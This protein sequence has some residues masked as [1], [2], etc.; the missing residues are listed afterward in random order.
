MKFNVTKIK[1]IAET[2][3]K[4][5]KNRMYIFPVGESRIDEIMSRFNRPYSI[6]KKELIPMVMVKMKTTDVNSYNL[7]K[8]NTWKWNQKA[9]CGCGC[10]PGFIGSNKNGLNLYVDV[11]ITL[12]KGE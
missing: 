12:K 1:I 5:K 8:N 10:S 3:N 4:E 9:G 2:N 11:T 7:L 6:Y